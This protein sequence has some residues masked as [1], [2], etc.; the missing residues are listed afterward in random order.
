MNS[1]SFRSTF[2][3]LPF[4]ADVEL[5]HLDGHPIVAGAV[6]VRSQHRGG[7]CTLTLTNSSRS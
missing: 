6:T 3:G 5:G 1:A 7:K 4:R 2:E